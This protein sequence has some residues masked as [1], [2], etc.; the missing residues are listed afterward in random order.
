MQQQET[1]FM[2]N[3]TFGYGL[4]ATGILIMFLSFFQ[5][6]RI[7][8]GQQEPFVFFHFDGVKIDL[9]KMMPQQP[10]MSAAQE[11]ANKYNLKINIPEPSTEPIETEIIPAKMLNDS[12]NLGATLLFMTFMLNFGGKLANIGVDLVTRK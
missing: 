6:F 7:F 11:L 1:K 2:V 9:R 4:L 10:D 5:V 8:T 12:A 3:M